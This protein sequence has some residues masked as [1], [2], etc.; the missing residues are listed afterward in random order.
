MI[1]KFNSF[2]GH[3]NEMAK[4]YPVG[5]IVRVDKASDVHIKQKNWKEIS[6]SQPE[7]V[8]GGFFYMEVTESARKWLSGKLI[9]NNCIKNEE[10][11]VPGLLIRAIYKDVGT[12]G[13]EYNIFKKHEKDVETYMKKSFFIGGDEKGLMK[14][15][16]EKAEVKEGEYIVTGLNFGLTKDTG[17]LVFCLFPKERSGR[18]T[19][20]GNG[21]SVKLE[22]IVNLGSELSKDQK[23]VAAD[24]FSNK[25]KATITYVDYED[26]FRI[27]TFEVEASA[28][29]MLKSYAAGPFFRKE[30]AEKHVEELKK[31]DQIF[32]ISTLKVKLQRDWAFP[33]LDL[34]SMISFCKSSG[35]PVTMKELLVQKRG[36]V[37][38]RKFG[39]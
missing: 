39:M 29:D 20:T 6:L 13:N 37:A 18:S 38:A 3:L 28:G 24:W 14:H 15:D 11:H 23:S 7:G 4:A 5:S 12:P 22:D 33:S 32:D 21:F 10:L 1:E 8:S 27:R 31:G 9:Y 34:K 17:S 35:V 36:E 25:L 30:D 26:K 2:E 16:G 19:F